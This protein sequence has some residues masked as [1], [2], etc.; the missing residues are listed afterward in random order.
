MV[1]FYQSDPQKLK[2][3]PPFFEPL[4]LGVC[5]AVKKIA[6]DDQALRVK[7]PEKGHQSLQILLID[8][9]GDRDPRF[10]EMACFAEMQIG[11]DQGFLFFPEQGPLRR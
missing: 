9:L 8:G 6:D 1:A 10:T 7:I 3:T 5:S 11:N 2:I 4:Q